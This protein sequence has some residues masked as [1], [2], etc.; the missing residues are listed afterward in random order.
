MSNVHTLG[1]VKCPPDSKAIHSQHG[2]CDVV[3][4]DGMMRTIE[5]ETREQDATPNVADLPVGVAPREVVFSETIQ[6]HEAVVDVRDLR[7][8]NPAKDMQPRKRA[9]Q[10]LFP[11]GKES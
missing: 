1:A 3:A 11:V 5:Y 6:H 9:T 4:A 10:Y 8:I 7:E 2:W